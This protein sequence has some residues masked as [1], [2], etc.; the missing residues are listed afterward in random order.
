MIKIK[1]GGFSGGTMDESPSANA[2]NTGSIPGPARRWGAPGP[3]CHNYWAHLLEPESHKP[4]SLH[5]ATA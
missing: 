4:L 1:F 2:G 5:A 3:I